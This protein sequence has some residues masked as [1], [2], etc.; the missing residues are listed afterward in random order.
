MAGADLLDAPTGTRHNG[1]VG[2]S[3]MSRRQNFFFSYLLLSLSAVAVRVF[4]VK[5]QQLVNLR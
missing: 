4:K 3:R 5:E 1:E 2:W